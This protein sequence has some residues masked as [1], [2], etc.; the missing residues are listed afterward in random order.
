MTSITASDLSDLLNQAA[1]NA[2]VKARSQSARSMTVSQ[3]KAAAMARSQSY[4][5]DYVP[6]SLVYRLELPHG[7]VHDALH[8]LLAAALRGHTK[9]DRVQLPLMTGPAPA[10]GFPLTELVDRLTE[11]S[12]LL[13]PTPTAETFLTSLSDPRCPFVEYY[14]LSGISALEPTQIYE[15]VALIR[16]PH[17]SSEF[18][19][20]LPPSFLGDIPLRTYLGGTILSVDR[21]VF[22]RYR[23]PTLSIDQGEEFTVG[24]ASAEAPGFDLQEFYLS[25]S[26]ACR[27]NVH[28][29][30]HWRY[31]PPAEITAMGGGGADTG[32]HRSDTYGSA[33]E[34]S[35]QDLQV[36]KNLYEALQALDSTTRRV[37]NVPL[38]R[39]VA[40]LDGKSLVDQAIDLG[41]ALEALYVEERAPEIGFRLR[42]RAARHLREDPEERGTV[43]EQLRRFYDLRSDAVHRGEL[44][45]GKKKI[46]GKGYE[47]SEVIEMARALCREGILKVIY[48]GG[49]PDWERMALA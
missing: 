23:A 36:A 33:N 12:V 16:L 41:I 2:V 32:W 10:S 40:S 19:H 35:A 44:G 47:H 43:I 27:A 6:L 13:G 18:P 29:K 34:V 5:G 24:V 4:Q 22:P 37:L 17:S 11:L 9:E 45:P 38:T 21:Y 14:L 8:S 49:L 30:V 42:I 7:P 31:I 3:Y 46:R 28:H 39:W 48:A 20:W 26:L 15:G 1:R 25:L